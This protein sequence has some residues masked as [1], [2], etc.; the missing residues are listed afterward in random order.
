VDLA[1]AEDPAQPDVDVGRARHL[2]EHDDAAVHPQ[3]AQRRS[4]PRVV[5]G[6]GIEARYPR[7]E[8]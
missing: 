1:L 2:L 5:E 3:V 6:R 8:R 7:P 4:H